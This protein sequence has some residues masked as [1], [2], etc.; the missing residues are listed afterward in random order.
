MKINAKFKSTVLALTSA[1]LLSSMMWSGPASASEPFI[2]EIKMF[3]GNFAPR[4]YAFCDGQ[5]LPISQNTA[6]FSLLGTTYGGDGRTTFALPDLRGRVAIQPGSGPGLSDY[7]LGQKGGAESVT[8]TAQEMPSHTHAITAALKGTAVAGNNDSPAGNTLALKA[9]SSN[10]STTAPAVDMQA[11]SVTATAVSTGGSQAH[12]NRMP[13]LGI[14]H[15]I[16]LQG[17]FPSRQ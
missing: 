6:L 2:A 15:I 13:Y 5:L 17:I 10:Y 3:G 1:T 11:G 9:R 8:L 7:T 12:E 4:G 14:Y 16:A